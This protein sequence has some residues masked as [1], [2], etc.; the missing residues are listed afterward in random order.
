MS[1]E[2]VKSAYRC[3]YSLFDKIAY[4]I[5]DYWKLGIL[6]RSVSF[7]SVWFESA[8]GNAQ[9][10]ALRSEFESSE[11]LPLRGLFWLSKDLF[12]AK[13]KDVALPEARDLDAL[14]N[15]LEHKNVKVVD[16]LALYG[17]LTKPFVDRLAHQIVREDLEQKTLRLLQLARAALIYLSLAMEVEELRALEAETGLIM[18]VAVEIYP[19]SFKY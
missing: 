12:D 18:P 7:C 14:R 2:Q 5:N 19:D 17:T 3:T 4:F 10:P 1:I 16:S 8:K 6:E 11:N 13:L 15:H 9:S